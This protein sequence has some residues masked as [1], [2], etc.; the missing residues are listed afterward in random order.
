MNGPAE[1][2]PILQ[3]LDAKGRETDMALGAMG[4]LVRIALWAK[5]EAGKGR[6]VGAE[7]VLTYVRRRETIL[8]ARFHGLQASSQ[9][10]IGAGHAKGLEVT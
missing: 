8:K 1:K 10:L 5:L 7:Q 6:P 3:A 2:P 4:E 9:A